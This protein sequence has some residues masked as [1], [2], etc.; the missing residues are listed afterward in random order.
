[1]SLLLVCS[2]RAQTDGPAKPPI[3]LKPNWI[4]LDPTALIALVD[5][6]T[7]REA[8]QVIRVLSEGFQQKNELVVATQRLSV[9]VTRSSGNWRGDVRVRLTMPCRGHYTVDL[10]GIT[11]KNCWWD[12]NNRRLY[13]KLPPLRLLALE[14][15]LAEK[16]LEREY[17]GWFRYGWLDSDTAQEL[18]NKLLMDDYT[19]RARAI[20]LERDNLRFAEQAGRDSVRRHI[21]ALLRIGIP[22][23]EV[24]VE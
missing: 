5:R 20:A 15:N 14:P 17:P 3:K 9:Q 18:E 6:L 21:R 22:N 7:A 11:L 8:E 16:A 23:A 13:L 4:R 24:I 10:T 1:V 12:A 2:T 19:S